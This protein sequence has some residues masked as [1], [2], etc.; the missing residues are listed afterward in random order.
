[1][2]DSGSTA[3]VLVSTGLVLFMTPGLAFFYGGMV[4]AKH[5]LGML[6]QNFFAMG[7]VSVLWAVVGFSLAFGDGGKYIGNFD[8]A[9]LTDLQHEATQQDRT[10]FKRLRLVTEEAAHT[11]LRVCHLPRVKSGNFCG[12]LPCATLASLSGWLFVERNFAKLDCA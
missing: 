11:G 3:W 5:V 9:F 2:L 8:F 10:L 1:M 4:R 12:A 6:M 7:L